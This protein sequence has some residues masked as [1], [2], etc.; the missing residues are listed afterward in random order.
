MSGRHRRKGVKREHSILAGL[1]PILERIAALPGV[2]SVIPGR[3]AVTRAS[4]PTLQLRPG[5]A[6]VTGLK[7]TARRGTAS[8][9]IFVVTS[10]PD[11]VLALL[12]E[13]I[14]G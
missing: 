11:R 8:Q 9:E 6:T 7:L 4:S 13:D 5:P 12:R 1:L 14:A 3:I 2:T 10:E